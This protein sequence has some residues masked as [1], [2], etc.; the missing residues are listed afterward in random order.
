MIILES[1]V[2][3]A[4]V[5]YL[6]FAGTPLVLKTGMYYGIFRR[7]EVRATLLNCIVIAGAP[8]LLAVVPIPLPPFLAFIAGIGVAIYLCSHYTEAPLYPEGIF[9]PV[10][11]ELASLAL[12]SFV[13]SPLL[14][15]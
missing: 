9:I 4:A 1:V 12:V 7:R 13:V 15:V 5:H 3:S 14:S 11:V 6:I 10:V 2:L 8:I